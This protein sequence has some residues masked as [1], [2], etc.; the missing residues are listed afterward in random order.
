MPLKKFG[1]NFF[2]KSLSNLLKKSFWFLKFLREITFYM[3]SDACN[4]ELTFFTWNHFQS[5]LWPISHIFH[6]IDSLLSEFATCFHNFV[7]KFRESNAFSTKKYYKLFHGI[8]LLVKA[9]SSYSKY[10]TE[11]KTESY[12]NLLSRN[13]FPQ[14]N[15][16]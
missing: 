8:F 12:W 2:V 15:W 3:W 1:S 14:H 10:Q 5:G 4:K 6:Q 16:F 9:N 7:K 13:I 11:Y